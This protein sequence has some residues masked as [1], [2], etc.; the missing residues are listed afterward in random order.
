LSTPTSDGRKPADRYHHGRLG[1]ALLEA[2]RELLEAEGPGALSLREVARRLGVSHNAPYR[3]FATREALLAALA[4]G[5]FV[6]LAA[7]TQRAAAEGRGLEAMGLAYIGFALAEPAV[8]R[9][10]FSDAVDKAA[11]P[12]LAAAARGSFAGLR[13]AVAR[14]HGTERA[15]AIAA[16]RWALVHGLAHLLLEDQLPAA[17]SPRADPLAA[18]AAV[19]RSAGRP[20]AEP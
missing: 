3:H 9:L 7:A 14:V 2:A 6:R 13:A 12:E 1:E 8:F 16:G 15:D 5:G 20:S 11:H 19:L 17:L 10:M 4:A 18:A